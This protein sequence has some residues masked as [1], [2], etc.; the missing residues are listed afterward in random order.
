MPDTLKSLVAEL[1][2]PKDAFV[3][4]FGMSAAERTILSPYSV[5]PD[6]SRDE[7]IYVERHEGSKGDPRRLLPLPHIYTGYYYFVLEEDGDYRMYE[8]DSYCDAYVPSPNV[9]KAIT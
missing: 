2:G 5:A 7:H 6:R 3:S 4:L 9:F 8:W 1:E